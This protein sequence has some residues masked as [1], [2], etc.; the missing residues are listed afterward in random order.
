[1][2]LSYK[3]NILNFSKHCKSHNNISPYIVIRSMFQVWQTIIILLSIV[4]QFELL[5][6][7][8]IMLDIRINTVLNRYFLWITNV[9]KEPRDI[10]ITIYHVEETIIFLTVVKLVENLQFNVTFVINHLICVYDNRSVLVLLHESQTILPHLL[11]S[12]S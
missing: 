3:G 10:Y 2:N 5:S 11:S 1:M 8:K 12:A 7:K 4:T 9:S 6:R